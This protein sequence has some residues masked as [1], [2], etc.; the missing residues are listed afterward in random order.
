MGEV[1]FVTLTDKEPQGG[2]SKWIVHSRRRLKLRRSI[3][4][5]HENLNLKPCGYAY[6]IGLRLIQNQ[7][8]GETSYEE[9]SIRS[10]CSTHNIQT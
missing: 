9:S 7:T 5:S 10:D 8:I 2:K 3:D 1:R 6:I 4:N